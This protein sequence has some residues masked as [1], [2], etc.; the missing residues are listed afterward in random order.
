MKNLNFG[1]FGGE[2]LDIQTDSD[3]DGIL[4]GLHTLEPWKGTQA[5]YNNMTKEAFHILFTSYS[6]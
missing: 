6:N 4:A 3:L 2:S 1:I 5:Q